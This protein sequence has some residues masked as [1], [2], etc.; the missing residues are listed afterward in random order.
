[1]QGQIVARDRPLAD[2]VN[3]LR[4][5]HVGAIFLTDSDFGAQR[6]SGVYNLGKPVA[7]LQAIAAAHG[8][9]ARAISP[10]V[11]VVSPR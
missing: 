2:V 11:L 8:G 10:W 7:A 1:M 6:V 4:R 3:D 9:V 5:Y